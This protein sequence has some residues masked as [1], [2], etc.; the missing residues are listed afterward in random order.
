MVRGSG[1]HTDRAR[2]VI[3]MIDRGSDVVEIGPIKYNFPADMMWAR[4][5]EGT[6]YR[7]DPE[8]FTLVAL[9]DETGPC[10]Q[11]A[12]AT[13]RVLK[14]VGRC[15]LEQCVVRRSGKRGLFELRLP[16][17]A[18]VSRSAVLDAITL[19]LREGR[20]SDGAEGLKTVS[21]PAIAGE[22]D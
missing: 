13:G 11:P 1:V 19:L 22:N 4:I 8:T 2:L 9:H 6:L 17:L 7:R 15:E 5:N 16:E 20:L 21:P 14:A 18:L 10:P 12:D 3:G